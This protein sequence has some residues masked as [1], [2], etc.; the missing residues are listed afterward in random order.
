MESET[1]VAGAA[2]V[3]DEASG[4]SAETEESVANEANVASVESVVSEACV[5]ESYVSQTRR[6]VVLLHVASHAFPFRESFG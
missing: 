3:Q 2:S 1:R 5:S 4:A 6:D